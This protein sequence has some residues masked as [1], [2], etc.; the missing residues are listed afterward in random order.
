MGN[1]TTWSLIF[2]CALLGLVIAVNY[3]DATDAI[4]VKESVPGST[5]QGPRQTLP[6]V[7]SPRPHDGDIKAILERPPFTRGRLPARQASA[8]K[9]TGTKPVHLSLEGVATTSEKRI[10]LIRDRGSNST[11]QLTEGSEYKGWVVAEVGAASVV[12]RN[13]SQSQT[14]KLEP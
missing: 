13:G 1:W 2:L 5:V 12:I 10:A 3:D 6:G 4:V 11:V 9:L 8:R 14:L 7:T